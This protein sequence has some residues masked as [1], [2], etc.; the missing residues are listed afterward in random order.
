[1]SCRVRRLSVP[2]SKAAVSCGVQQRCIVSLRMVVKTCSSQ[3]VNIRH[4][5]AWTSCLHHPRHL[6]LCCCLS[7]ASVS[8]HTANFLMPYHTGQVSIDQLRD[9]V[10]NLLRLITIP[11]L[12]HLLTQPHHRAALCQLSC[13]Q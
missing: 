12:V 10:W 5:G 13:Q 2:V 8:L 1:M 9:R 11:A 6:L 4:N 7:Y 3:H